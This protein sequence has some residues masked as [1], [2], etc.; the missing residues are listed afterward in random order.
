MK[1]KQIA[2]AMIVISF[3]VLGMAFLTGCAGFK[4]PSVCFKTDYGTLCYELP[5]IKGLK[6]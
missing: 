6:K 1:P 5:E 4:A 3:I 2:V